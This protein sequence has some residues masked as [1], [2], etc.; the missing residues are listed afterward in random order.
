MWA[1]FRG[2]LADLL[3]TFTVEETKRKRK[4]VFLPK[5]GWR[6]RFMFNFRGS[7]HTQG[8]YFVWVS[9]G[10]NWLPLS[11]LELL[12]ILLPLPGIDVVG[13]LCV[14]S[15][16]KKWTAPR[17]FLSSHTALLPWMKP[18]VQRYCTDWQHLKGKLTDHS[19]DTQGKLDLDLLL[20][21]RKSSVYPKW[22]VHL[23]NLERW[24]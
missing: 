2:N 21:E 10:D 11:A 22:L 3:T 19:W 20:K 8:R 13:K 9:R 5:K 17:G 16:H 1:I 12:E 15:A 14:N 4:T 24:I 18:L 6:I 7:A 23:V